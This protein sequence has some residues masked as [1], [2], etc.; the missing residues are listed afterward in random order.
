LK[1]LKINN[2]ETISLSIKQIQVLFLYQEDLLLISDTE[3]ANLLL[4]RQRVDQSLDVVIPELQTLFLADK[5]D[6]PF[7]ELNHISKPVRTFDHPQLL[8]CLNIP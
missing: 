5:D 2:Y 8:S 3:R 6:D 4:S 7:A 1:S